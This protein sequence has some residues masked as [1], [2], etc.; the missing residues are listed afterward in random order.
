MR[1]R[2]VRNVV[3]HARFECELATILKFSVKLASNAQEEVAL[4][5]PVI[6]EI[7]RRVLDHANAH[8]VEVLGT[9]IGHAPLTA[10]L[11]SLDLRPISNAEGEIRYLHGRYVPVT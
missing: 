2:V 8:R 11:C 9:P 5:A 3:T 7:A 4:N 10:V 6:R 1:F